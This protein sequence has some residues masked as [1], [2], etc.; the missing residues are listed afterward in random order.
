MLFFYLNSVVVPLTLIIALS[1]HSNYKL[2]LYT[3]YTLTTKCTE[4]H[5]EKSLKCIDKRRLNTK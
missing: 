2:K 4:R 1:Y 5:T 3:L